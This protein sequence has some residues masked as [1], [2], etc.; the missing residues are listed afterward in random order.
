MMGED[1]A[2]DESNLEML[3]QSTGMRGC[4]ELLIQYIIKIGHF[5]KH[6]VRCTCCEC[7]HDEGLSHV[8]RSA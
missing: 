8:F 7:G 6:E 1:H 2:A 4:C 3:S 5:G